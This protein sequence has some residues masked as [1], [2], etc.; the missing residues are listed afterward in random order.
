MNNNQGKEKTIVQLK[1]QLHQVAGNP[2]KINPFSRQGAQTWAEYCDICRSLE[3]ELKAAG[4][5]F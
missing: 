1:K 2:P 3:N 4:E 5:V